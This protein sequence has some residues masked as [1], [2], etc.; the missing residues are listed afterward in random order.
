MMRSILLE[1]RAPEWSTLRNLT[2]VAGVTL[3]IGLFVFNKLKS[4]FFEYL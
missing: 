2:L 1:G 4:R 3:T